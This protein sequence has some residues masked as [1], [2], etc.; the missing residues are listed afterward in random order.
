MPSSPIRKLATYA[1]QAKARGRSVLHFNIGQPDIETPKISTEI[2]KNYQDPIVAYGPSQG[3]PEYIDALVGYYRQHNI[4]LKNQEILVT[5]GGSEAIVMGLTV[6]LDPGDEVLIPEPFYAN[7][8]GFAVTAGVKIRPITT[9]LEDDWQLP[10]VQE[11]EKQIGSKTKAIMICNPNNPTGKVYGRD[12]LE[13]IIFLAKKH[14]IFLFSDEVYREFIFS[15]D[16]H[17]SLLDFEDAKEH[18]VVMDSIS[19]RFSSCGSRIGTFISRNK[20]VMQAA[21]S[22]AQARLCPPTISQM[23]AIPFT[24][25]DKKYF[26]DILSEYK[27]R[28]DLVVSQL[29]KIEGLQF[30]V[31]GGAFYIIVKLPVRDAEKFATWLLTDFHINNETIMLAPANGFY[32]TKGLG[33]DEVRFA[34]VLDCDKIKRAMVIFKQGLYHYINTIGH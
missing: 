4:L 21:L 5:V 2:L 15:G 11:I 8:N 1:D 24:T 23:M 29:K 13:K 31:P 28:R 26:V 9:R 33:E 18:V 17:V 19:K 10:E 22:F 14:N 16:K 32:N 30:N 34:F 25:L 3:L 27:K 6:C 20:K 7:Y 12:E